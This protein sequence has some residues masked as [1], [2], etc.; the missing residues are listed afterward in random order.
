MASFFIFFSPLFFSLIFINLN[1]TLLKMIE[2]KN[3]LHHWF[4]KHYNIYSPEQYKIIENEITKIRYIF[5]TEEKEWNKIINDYR[6]E[7]EENQMTCSCCNSKRN[8]QRLVTTSVDK[9]NIQHTVYQHYRTKND[10]IYYNIFICSDCGN[11]WRKVSYYDNFINRELSYIQHL[12][13]VINKKEQYP[14]AF[15]RNYVKFKEFHAESIHMILENLVSLKK[16][17]TINKSIFD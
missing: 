7:F 13:D 15:N 3:K 2:T 11:Q 4:N 6:R 12:A 5:L 1:S 9:S 16:L 17:R 10:H 8:E 14:D